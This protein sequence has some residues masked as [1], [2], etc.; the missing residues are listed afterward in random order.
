VSSNDVLNHGQPDAG[1]RNT[2][3]AGLATA[4]KLPEDF[5]LLPSGDTKTSI[6]HADRD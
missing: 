3:A 2:P 1:A 4:N 6:A 5:P